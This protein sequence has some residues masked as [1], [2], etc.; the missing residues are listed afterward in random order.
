MMRRAKKKEW[1]ILRN[2]A[3]YNTTGLSLEHTEI[4]FGF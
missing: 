4:I 3:L 1:K 2:N